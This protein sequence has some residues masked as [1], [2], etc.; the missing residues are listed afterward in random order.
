M[1]NLLYDE[2]NLKVKFKTCSFI[3]IK[4]EIESPG[5]Q[6]LTR[7][8]P[9]KTTIIYKEEHLVIIRNLINLQ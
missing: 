2:C 5:K 8:N 1:I 4:H 9:T 7:T 6:L 3:S